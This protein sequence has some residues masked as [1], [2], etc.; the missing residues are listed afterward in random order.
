MKT[1]NT[2]GD[3]T[4]ILGGAPLPD[5]IDIR[6]GADD[7]GFPDDELGRMLFW[8]LR[9]H[10]DKLSLKFRNSDITGMDDQTKRHLINDIHEVLGIRSDF[11]DIL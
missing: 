11:G 1:R 7:P 5:D 4:P 3:M 6:D 10:A 2:H 9:L 8:L